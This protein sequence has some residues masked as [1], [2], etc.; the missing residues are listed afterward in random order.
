MLPAAPSQAEGHAGASSRPPEQATAT[1]QPVTGPSTPNRPNRPVT[2]SLAAA[3]AASRS[4]HGQPCALGTDHCTPAPAAT[5]INY[6]HLLAD[7]HH[8]QV[9][10]DE[11][12]GF[13][14]LYGTATEATSEQTPEQIPG[15]LSI[16][17]V[18]TEAAPR[19]EAT[20]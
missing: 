10:D 7:T 15:Q 5:G 4:R 13:H 18:L 17:E 20:R 19:Q 2:A 3:R 9:A 11:R 6:L 16:D 1:C 12:I 8:T 14:S